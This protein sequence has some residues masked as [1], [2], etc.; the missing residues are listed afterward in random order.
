MPI[1]S[2]VFKQLAYK[3]E[4]IYGTAA[5]QASGQSLRRVQSTIDLSKDTYQSNEIRTDLQMSD[6]R[7]GVRRVGG[8]INGELS[9]GTWKDFMQAI[10]KRDYAA[11]APS[12]AMSV[13][14]SGTGPT[15]TVARAAGSFLTDGIKVGMVTRLSVGTFNAANLLKNLF[16]TAVTAL[17]ITVIPLN[18]AAMVAEG[19]IASGTLTVIGK[20]TFIPSSGHTDKSFSIEH[21]YSDAGFS[22]SELFLGCKMAQAQLDLPPSGIATINWDVRGQDYADTAAKRTSIATTAQY[23]TSPTAATTTGSLASVN[24][25]VRLGGSTVAVLTGLSLT[26]AA[27]FTGDPVVGS[28]FIPNQF[29]GRVLVSG[30][31]TMYFDGVSARDAF[32]NETEVDIVAAFTTDNSGTADFLSLALPRVKYGGANKDDG[33]KGIV[34]TVPFQ[35]LYNSAGGTGVQTEKTTLMIQDSQ[36]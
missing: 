13:T 25:L 22:Q 28:N 31:A 7:H 16:V 14:I 20:T 5:G 36:A 24:G 34:M 18:G 15:Y 19:P 23:F 3:A 2:G 12:T 33:E 27:N 9:P 35:A 17:N 10:L 1:A 26:I 32:V 8:S 4:G 21:W 6:F 11:V 29:P 30:Q